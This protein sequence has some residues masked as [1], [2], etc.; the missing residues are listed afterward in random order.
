M[1]VRALAGGH[2]YMQ[3]RDLETGLDEGGAQ[4]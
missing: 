2:V 4:A 1:N 3:L